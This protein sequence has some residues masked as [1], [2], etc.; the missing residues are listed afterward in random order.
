MIALAYQVEIIISK[1]ASE[2][3][4]SFLQISAIKIS[5]FY[6]IWKGLFALQFQKIK[7]LLWIFC[8]GYCIPVS[9]FTIQASS[10]QKKGPDLQRCLMF[11]FHFMHARKEKD[12]NISLQPSA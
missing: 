6:M 10:L 3:I 12:P 1:Y 2:G 8:M 11:V 7:T 9:S 4:G 5:D